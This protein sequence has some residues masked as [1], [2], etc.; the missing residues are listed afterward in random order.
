MMLAKHLKA[1]V[2]K[3]NKTQELKTLLSKSEFATECLLSSVS[4]TRMYSSRKF[5]FQ[6]DVVFYCTLKKEASP[7]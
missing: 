2:S 5:E 7:T 1:H 3:E 4:K 6:R